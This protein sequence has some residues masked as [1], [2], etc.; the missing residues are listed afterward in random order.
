MCTRVRS[1][2]CA[3]EARRAFFL[4]RRRRRAPSL[5]RFCARWRVRARMR[6]RRVAPERGMR[7]HRRGM[8]L[9]VRA[10][11]CR[12]PLPIVRP[13]PEAL[14]APLSGPDAPRDGYGV[15]RCCV[16]H[17]GGVAL[18]GGRV[19]TRVRAVHSRRCW[20]CLLAGGVKFTARVARIIYR[21]GS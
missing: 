6:A 18:R 9:P 21:H 14:D 8:P 15:R 13:M 3:V 19:A 11:C 1:P 16:R 20:C 5:P 2:L 17:C 7:S 12:P 4:F 10:F